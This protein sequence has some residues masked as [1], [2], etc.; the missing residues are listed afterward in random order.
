MFGSKVANFIEKADN[1]LWIIIKMAQNYKIV[2][3]GID[4]NKALGNSSY[5]LESKLTF[6]YK[7]KEITI[8]YFKGVF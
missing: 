6:F 8:E 3:I 7:N 1:A 4:T 2:D 5:I